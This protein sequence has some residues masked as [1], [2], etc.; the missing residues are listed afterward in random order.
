[1]LED[2][3]QPKYV[4]VM[5]HIK[6]YI[7]SGQ[8]KEN[9]K[10]PSENK[11]TQQFGVSRHTVRK[12]IGNL[13]NEGWLYSVQGKGTFIANKN[14]QESIATQQIIGV[15]TTYIKD[16]IFPEIIEGMDQVLGE[17]GYSILLGNTYNQVEKERQCL[18]NM[19]SN[20]VKALIV[21]PTKSALPNPNIDLYQ[22]LQEKNIPILFLHGHYA[23]LDSSYLVTNDI[24]GGYAIT[25]HLIDLGHTHLGGI[26]KSDDVQGHL[27]YQG[28]I[29]AHR[30]HNIPI[31]E[32]AIT[33]FTTE[34]E[35]SIFKVAGDMNPMLRRLKDCTGLVCYNDK[36]A[37][38]V[39]E[40]IEEEGRKI[41]EDLSIV[42]FDNSRLAKM[43][44]LTSIAHPKKMMGQKAA[45][46][47]LEMLSNPNNRNNHYILNT[48]INYGES[49]G[50]INK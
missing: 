22:E 1:M 32:E 4:L 9:D 25:K 50:A 2:K 41:P 40:L 18:L 6:D 27:R 3:N 21:E 16:Y 17:Q 14:P 48:D 29:K 13:V 38:K 44:S 30:E 35:K 11:L 12:A 15:M 31:H 49:T 23:N 45:S 26:F 19:I 37:I 33:W 43:A 36:V 42:S 28:F 7:N 39:M 20:G 5:E 47:I 46:I 10:M 24:E 8:L 34:D